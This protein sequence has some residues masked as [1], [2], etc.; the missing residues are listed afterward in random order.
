MP[1]HPFKSRTWI[2]TLVVNPRVNTSVFYA[3]LSR[4][5]FFDYDFESTAVL[6]LGASAWWRQPPPP[7]STDIAILNRGQTSVLTLSFFDVASLQSKG[8]TAA[9]VC[10]VQQYGQPPGGAQL[11]H[12]GTPTIEGPLSIRLVQGQPARRGSGGYDSFTYLLL[13]C[14][15]SFALGQVHCQVPSKDLGFC[16]HQHR[17]TLF[18]PCVQLQQRQ[19]HFNNAK[20][21]FLEKGV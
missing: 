10:Y 21:T 19:R 2:K 5:S 11:S 16:L 4:F 18:N 8:Q 17:D 1:S 15:G 20:K 7:H 12:M 14:E 3:K 6:C 13:L 9:V